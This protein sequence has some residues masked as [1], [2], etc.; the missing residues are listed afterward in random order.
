[1]AGYDLSTDRLY[2]HVTTRKSRTEFLAFVRDHKSGVRDRLAKEKKMSDAIVAAVSVRSD[3]LL[4]SDS[5]C[6]RSGLK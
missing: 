1:M 6:S 4:H 5:R 2:G 3:D